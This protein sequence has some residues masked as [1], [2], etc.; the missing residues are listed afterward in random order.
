MFV[1]ALAFAVVRVFQCRSAQISEVAARLQA[2]RV[3]IMFKCWLPPNAEFLDSTPS[4]LPAW[5]KAALGEFALVDMIGVDATRCELTASDIAELQELSHLSYLEVYGEAFRNSELA[6]VGV[7]PCLKTLV[8]NATSV[9]DDGIDGLFRS[10]SLQSLDLRGGYIGDRGVAAAAKSLQLTRLYLENLPITDE[11]LRAVS[12]IDSLRELYLVNVA[13][14]NDGIAVL[15]SVRSLRTLVI[16]GTEVTGGGIRHIG[17]MRALRDLRFRVKSLDNDDLPQLT[18]L[19]LERLDVTESPIDNDGLFH[20]VR[21]TSLR[22]L[23]LSYTDIDDDGMQHLRGLPMLET[24]LLR[25][26]NITDE[27]LS[28]LTCFQNLHTVDI[29]GT[30]V[31]EAGVKSL[32]N[33]YPRLRIIGARRMRNGLRSPL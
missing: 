4:P 24:L 18:G 10:E 8:L 33:V 20:I 27:G 1:V 28:Q 23:T 12:T 15:K 32:M 11:G 16:D 6:A 26:L 21:L 13:V 3:R 7:F 2:R 25:G 9:T 29:S 31:S 30:R 5:T 14:T 22:E 19:S 17:Q